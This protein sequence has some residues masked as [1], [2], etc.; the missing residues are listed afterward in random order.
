MIAASS[1]IVFGP[2]LPVNQEIRGAGPDLLRWNV[3]RG[4]DRNARRSRDLSS[5]PSKHPPARKCRER[6]ARTAR[7]TRGDRDRLNGGSARR[8]RSRRDQDHVGALEQLDFAVEIKRVCQYI[9]NHTARVF[10]VMK[11]LS[12][13]LGALAGRDKGV[14]SRHDWMV[15]RR[16]EGGC[17][18]N[19]NETELGRQVAAG[20]FPPGLIA[21]MHLTTPVRP[22]VFCKA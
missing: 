14:R 8:R 18:P 13:H 19:H 3:D 4:P 2:I 7:R 1:A 22:S 20:D 6:C 9:G 15:R 17:D 16:C 11:A 10:L 5:R 12:H 21:R